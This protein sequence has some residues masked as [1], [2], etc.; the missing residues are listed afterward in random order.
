[1]ISI[2]PSIHPGE[3]IFSVLSRFHIISGYYYL[4]SQHTFNAVFN[5]K[6]KQILIDFPYN[7]ESLHTNTNVFK[8]KKHSRDWVL[9]HTSFGYYTYFMGKNERKMILDTM[10]GNQYYNIHLKTGK[11]ASRIYDFSHLKYCKACYDEDNDKFGYACWYSHHQ[12]PGVYVCEKHQQELY[13]ST[14]KRDSTELI[15]LNIESI[16]EFHNSELNKDINQD[17]LAEIS[18]LSL[19]INQSEEGYHQVEKLSEIYRNFLKLLMYGRYQKQINSREVVSDLLLFYGV[20]TIEHLGI[21]KNI[22]IKTITKLWTNQKSNSHPL[23]H[24][25]LIN[26]LYSKL[27][28]NPKEL[29]IHELLNEGNKIH[30]QVEVN[31]EI[32]KK[33]LVCLNPYCPSYN[34]DMDSRIKITISKQTIKSNYKCH[35]CGQN[36]LKRGSQFNPEDY[37]W[38]ILLECGWLLKEMVKQLHRGENLK[39]YTIARI[40]DIPEAAVRSTIEA[41]TSSDV[42]SKPIMKFDKERDRN[43]WVRLMHSNPKL[44]ISQIRKLNPG[45][46]KRLYNNDKAWFN[47]LKYPKC[48]RVNKKTVK[49][50][51]RDLE[52][53]S[54]L[55]KAAE[56]LLTKY[57]CVR[58]TFFSLLREANLINYYRQFDKMPISLNFARSAAEEWDVY[59]LRRTQE[60]I[61]RERKLPIEKRNRRKELTVKT[62]Y[63]LARSKV[64]KEKIKKMLDEHFEYL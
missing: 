38:D 24:L 4:G 23:Y 2:F 31:R 44:T 56:N 13:L 54:K 60:I 46:Y 14:N 33:M 53:L 1:M 55:Q 8:V 41:D 3:S 47:K 57:P 51:K 6:K 62:G 11:A 37:K 61:N 63:S 45:L 40:L 19:M 29:K 42:K 36:Y 25:L 22:F 18:L 52:Y 30:D 5:N 9:S 28:Y 34:Q 17:R 48:K 7:I 43:E 50:D 49:W 64:T 15:P 59:Y 10:L 35:K 21:E 27:G 26:F 12:L 20:K 58:I 16:L 39:C 32:I